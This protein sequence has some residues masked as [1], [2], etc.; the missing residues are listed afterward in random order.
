MDFQGCIAI[1]IKHVIRP[2][3]RKLIFFGQRF[4]KS[5]AGETTLAATF[6]F[7]D[8]PRLL[9]TDSVNRRHDILVGHRVPQSFQLPEIFREG[10][11]FSEGEEANLRSD[12]FNSAHSWS[13][14][15]FD[16]RHV[17][18]H[19]EAH[20]DGAPQRLGPRGFTR[21]EL[22]EHTESKLSHSAGPCSCC[23]VCR[24]RSAIAKLFLSRSR[25]R[26]VLVSKKTSWCLVLQA[27]ARHIKKRRLRMPAESCICDSA[28]CS[29]HLHKE[30]CGR[31]VAAALKVKIETHGRTEDREIAFC[32]ECWETICR[33]LPGLHNC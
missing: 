3:V 4:E 1:P 22:T 24:A 16:P 26:S 6:T 31:P 10:A 11:A 5:F 12:M 13:K 20:Y 19:A 33:N 7:S 2:P 9:H 18:E 21:F 23:F 29:S 27:G 8:A 14:S 32:E 25:Y 15:P 28:F 30:R 17:D